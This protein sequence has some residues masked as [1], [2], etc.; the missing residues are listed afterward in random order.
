MR[1]SERSIRNLVGSEGDLDGASKLLGHADTST[2][3]RYYRLKP[4][5][6]PPVC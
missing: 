6:S 4:T 2:T 1:F 3:A 5:E